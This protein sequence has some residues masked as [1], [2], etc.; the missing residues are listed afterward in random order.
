MD[1][2]KRR[3]RQIVNPGGRFNTPDLANNQTEKKKKTTHPQK[4]RKDKEDL[5]NN[6]QTWPK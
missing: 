6:E 4:I 2:I 3:N 5:K 1:R